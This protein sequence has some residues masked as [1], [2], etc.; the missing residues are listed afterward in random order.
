LLR[1]QD[2]PPLFEENSNFY[3]FSKKSFNDAG[4]KRIGLHPAMFI[5][6]KLEAMDIDEESDF[7]IAELLYKLHNDLLNT[8][9]G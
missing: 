7:V 3:I 4:N 5:M 6:E 9:I 1:T 8:T 2:L